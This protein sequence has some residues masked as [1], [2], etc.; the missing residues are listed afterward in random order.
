MKV[1][2]TNVSKPGITPKYPQKRGNND[3]A[4]K[5][6]FT[7]GEVA[8]KLDSY[9][10]SS[11]KFM[12]KLSDGLGEVQN[13]VINAVGTALIA[14]IFIKYNFLSE[15][16]E[17]T[18]T[19]SAWRQPIS[20]AITVGTQCA[21]VIPFNK[22]VAEIANKGVLAD[23]YNQTAFQTE[24]H[25]K[26]EIKKQNPGISDSAL[27]AKVKEAMDKQKA[28]MIND[29]RNENTVHITKYKQD[30]K[31]KV[32]KEVFDN[33][34][35]GTIDKIIDREEAELKRLKEEKQVYRIRRREF[36]RT[37]TD[38]TMN[39]LTELENITK[40]EDTKEIQKALKE[41]IKSLK[42]DKD[43]QELKY[44]AEEVL[45]L[46]RSATAESKD[47]IAKAMK[48]KIE[49]VRTTAEKYSKLP[50]KNAVEEA[51]KLE[52]KERVTSVENT[53]N[54]YKQAKAAIKEGKT[55]KE[56]EE[57]FK[58]EAKTNKRLAK[59]EIDFVKEVADMFKK[60][61]KGNISSVKQIGGLIVGV[62]M[63]PIACNILNDI[64]PVFMDTF[65]PNLS[66]SKKKE[67]N[68]HLVE[69]APKQ[70]KEVNNG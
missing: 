65:F 13:T 12:K 21:V 58:A 18:R 15:T 42:G 31:F 69:Q 36:Y 25:I 51:I 1:E 56:I 46:S 16:D 28:D 53:L 60:Q 45:G 62:A 29:I 33:A 30:G 24:A 43:A 70:G 10:P 6:K 5:G 64:Y 4:F 67:V 37:H 57:M 26:K 7:A 3:V 17:D 34:V 35:M 9:M 63:I 59:K 52:L 41:K 19:Y 61:V 38:K 68:K 23:D 55:V 8:E 22:V 2:F 49:K 27:K 39:F 50:D 11:I 40:K 48:N 54:F 66:N 44:I 14:P 32:N 47:S 20:A